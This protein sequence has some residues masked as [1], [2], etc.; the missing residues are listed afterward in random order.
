VSC[1]CETISE[2][3]GD[4]AKAYADEHLQEVAVRAEGWLAVYRCPATGA[5]WIEDYPN[6]EAH[7]GG[8][9]RLR[10]TAFRQSNR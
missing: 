7:G 1:R 6:S 4:E 9:V 8:I 5:E 2:L 3:H 10:R